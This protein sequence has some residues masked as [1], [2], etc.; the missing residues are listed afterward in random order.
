[1]KTYENIDNQSM[2]LFKSTNNN[3]NNNKIQL[4]F[5]CYNGPQMLNVLFIIFNILTTFTKKDD[6][7]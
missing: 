3:N 4:A 6:T 5:K 7:L 1:M 2:K